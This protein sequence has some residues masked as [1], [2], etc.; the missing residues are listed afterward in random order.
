MRGLLLW[1][2]AAEILGIVVADRLAL[3]ASALAT[4]L[5][6]LLG[7]AVLLRVPYRRA[8]LAIWLA[9]LAGVL[10]MGFDLERADRDRVERSRDVTLQARVCDVRRTAR[11]MGLELCAVREV[12]GQ[13]ECPDRASQA[14]PREPLPER[15][16]L[17]A[18]SETPQAHVLEAL[19][20]G[21]WLRARVRVRRLEGLRNPGGST[22]ALAQRRRGLG[23]AAVLVDPG[24]LVRIEGARPDT[25]PIVVAAH[26]GDRLWG[27]RRRIAARLR[28]AGAGGGLLAALSVGDRSGLD[29]TS[30]AAIQALGLSH[31]LAVSGLHLAMLMGLGFAGLRAVGV[32]ISPLARR[33]DVRAYALVGA[34][35]C[36]TAYALLTGF[37][38]PVRRALVFV[39]VLALSWGFARRR[40]PIHALAL[41][42]LIVLADQPGALFELGAQLSFA[43]TAA[44]LLARATV[45]QSGTGIRSWLGTSLSTSALAIG[46]TAP[47]LAFHGLSSSP[48]ALLWNLIA[49]PW[50]GA[51]LLPSAIA[52]AS[53]AYLDF[54]PLAGPV[55]GI[56]SRL[57]AASLSGVDLIARS[58]PAL[59]ALTPVAWLGAGVAGFLVW[60]GARTPRLGLRVLL[61]GVALIWI[62]T[63][64]AVSTFPPAP[65][66]VAFDVG[67]GDAILV[68]GTRGALLVDGGRAVPGRY[69]LGRSSVLPALRALG[70]TRLDAVVASHADLDHRGGLTTILRSLP[71]DSL[72]LPAGAEHDAG[73]GDLI[74]VAERRGIR[75][76]VLAAGDPAFDVADLRVEALWPP[77]SNPKQSLSRNDRSLVLRVRVGRDHVL[78]TGDAGADVERALLASDVDVTAAILKLP[79]HGSRTSSTPE[80]LA[81]VGADVLLLSAPC[82]G[83]SGLPDAGVLERVRAG[84]AQLGWT[85]RDGASTVRPKGADG[86][87]QLLRWAP[88]RSCIP[89]ARSTHPVLGLCP[90]VPGD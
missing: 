20:P 55:I 68:Q 33:V 18:S 58:Q 79:H 2:V 52:S 74:A 29:E 36:A 73:F 15:L 8:W 56:A 47:L 70:V 40:S 25:Q 10:A 41:A 59:P 75:R 23:G 31:L 76:R 28:E 4:A 6:S 50:T 32:R 69:D 19:P 60:V 9:F 65:R 27:A 11:T 72:W 88:M 26:L 67:Q 7:M 85:G 86:A 3:G 71:V 57:A 45:D 87:R 51:V 83:R 44:L 13:S 54:E 24:L 39:W 16:W 48:A 12:V 21:A 77:R 37:E 17:S 38:V 35:L 42:A 89:P 78:L 22:W 66:I 81:A 1:L 84:G 5:L 64:P 34:A 62:R 53:L 63:A 46:A 49:V 61:V 82:G 90:T 80:F 43:A 30:G 14:A